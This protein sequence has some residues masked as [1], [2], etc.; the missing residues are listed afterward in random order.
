MPRRKPAPP[1]RR[2]PDDAEPIYCGP[3]ALCVVTGRYFE[4]V[5]RVINRIRKIKDR[6]TPVTALYDG[7][8]SRALLEL[9]HCCQHIRFAGRPTLN[10]RQLFEQ[11]PQEHKQ[12]PLL[13]L[14]SNHFV[15]LHQCRVIDTWTNQWTPLGRYPY[16]RRVRSYW[17]IDP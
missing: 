10:L 5:R 14:V 8:V 16:Q 7:E 2:N 17:V 4:D 15:V 13:V 12:R 3:Y 6:T 11:V 9:G 1:R